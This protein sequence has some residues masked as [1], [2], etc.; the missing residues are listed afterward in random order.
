[1]ARQ[2]KLSRASILAGTVELIGTAGVEAATVRRICGRLGVSEAALY[3]HFGSKDEVAWAAYAGIVAAMVEEKRHLVED[4]RPF[5]LK[6][7]DWIDLSYRFFDRHPEAFAYVLLMPP[8][9]I[10]GDDPIVTAQG[11]LFR[12]MARRAREAGSMRDMPSALA[13]SHFVGLLLGVPRA[14]R[15]GAL[16]GPALRYVDEVSWAA[17]QVLRP[18]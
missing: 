3:R 13:L 12:T 2:A 17:W 5:R 11:D 10:A 14:I 4:P 18:P 15:N 9:P 1:M 6:V 7:R 8:P 16:P